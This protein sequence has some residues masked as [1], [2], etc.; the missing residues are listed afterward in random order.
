MVLKLAIL[1][2]EPIE[3]HICKLAMGVRNTHTEMAKV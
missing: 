2:E 1:E 3:V